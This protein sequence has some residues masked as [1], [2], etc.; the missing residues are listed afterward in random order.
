MADLG[1]NSVRKGQMRRQF[2]FLVEALLTST[3]LL[4]VEPGAKVVDGLPV[5]TTQPGHPSVGR[6][7]EYW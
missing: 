4:C 5:R 7:S 3:K 1:T 6:R 2:G